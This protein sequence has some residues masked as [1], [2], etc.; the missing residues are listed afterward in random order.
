MLTS[1]RDFVKAATAAMT[2]LLAS[3]AS[4]GNKPSS[5]DAR[6]N[7]LLIITDDQGYGDLGCSGNPKIRTPNIDGLAGQSVEFTRYY[8][9]PVCAPTRACLLTGRYNHRTGAID[10]YLGRAMMHN[11][12]V[13]L[14]EMLKA[15]GYHTGIFGKWHLGDNYPMRPQDQGFDEV[16]VH[17]GGGIGQ[18]SDPP[19]GSSYMD[20]ILQHNGVQK[21]FQGY[22][23]D[24]YTDAA[25]RFIEQHRSS[26]FFCY[27]PTN[28]PHT[29]LDV[30]EEWVKSY[31]D[32]G[33]DD[34]T[35]RIYAMVENIDRNVGR[36]LAKL[37]ELGLADNTIVLYMHDNGAQQ[38][39]RYNGG[40]R[41]TKG[42]V[43]EGGIRSPLF[44]RWPARL[45]RRK[46][47]SVAAHIDITPTLL[48]W[49][50]IREPA[51]VRF[52]GV[53]LAGRMDGSLAT[54]EP[55]DRSIFIQWHRGDEPQPYNNCAVIT[56]QYKLVNGK[57]L[58]DLLA[59]P[60]ES[61]DIAALQPDRVAQMRQAY[62]AWFA[63]VNRDKRFIPPRII[64][65]SAKENPSTLT[66]QDWRGP[67]A[68]WTPKSLGYWEVEFARSGNYSI[69][70]RFN[71]LKEPA[72]VRF[73]FED[74][75]VS[76][77]VKS[78]ATSCNFKPVAIPARKGR[79]QAQIELPGQTVGVNF[80]D[81]YR[82]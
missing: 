64:L 47:D 26:P 15:A 41:G 9:S 29:P 43:Y 14:A 2:P 73:Q 46:V 50:G 18:P 25:L 22:C 69:N 21:K 49:C 31:R 80:V 32:A 79:L 12:E 53:S 3:C 36:L 65:G 74:V 68:G 75:S 55:Q 27:L 70:C 48:E 62:E 7:I 17:L 59:D 20:P 1:R 40:L 61:R 23:T 77:T 56:Q 42:T 82:M 39:D 76:Q 44:I 60:A 19:G 30:P 5:A 38:K 28:A 8:V 35:A 57:E 54:I 66:R 51:G 37:D 63:D 58:Y 52:D 24:V 4:T 11:D 78:G 72:T 45:R 34:T 13:T 10:T 81:V 6:P 71:A 16:L 67:Q 33:L